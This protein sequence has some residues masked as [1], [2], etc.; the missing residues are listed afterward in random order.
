MHAVVQTPEFL[1]VLGNFAMM[2][3]GF[4][5]MLPSHEGTA[6][7]LVLTLNQVR[8][9]CCGAEMAIQKGLA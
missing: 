2:T 4:L 5:V 6:L 1:F 9:P 7:A 3:Y 8:A